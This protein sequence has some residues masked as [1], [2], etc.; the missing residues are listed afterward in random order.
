MVRTAL[1][2][3]PAGY[4]RRPPPAALSF[5]EQVGAGWYEAPLRAHTSAIAPI[6]GGSG[7][8]VALVSLRAHLWRS[9][10]S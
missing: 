5:A 8:V 3:A 10:R 2:G 6:G 9:R 4:G 7:V 1:W